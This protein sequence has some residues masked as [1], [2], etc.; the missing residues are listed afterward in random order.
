MKKILFVIPDLVVGGAEIYLFKITK[1][2]SEKN[3]ISVLV[4]GCSSSNLKKCFIKQKNIKFFE[5][6]SLGF[7]SKL[8]NLYSFLK[9]KNYDKVISFLNIANLACLIS[10]MLLYNRIK[11]SISI[12]N[13]LSGYY[14][15]SFKD[16]I[17]VIL[18]RLLLF[19]C[20]EVI[21]NSKFSKDE[22]ENTFLFPKSKTR[23]IYNPNYDDTFKKE[24]KKNKKNTY[25]NYICAIGSLT[26][27]KNF[28]FL[29]KVF[30]KLKKKTSQN[31]IIVGDG[32]Q[33][34]Y[35]KNY[36]QE[37]KLGKRVIL[38][39]KVFPPYHFIKK[40]DLII[41]CSLWEGLPNILVE[42]ALLKKFIIASDCPGGIREIMKFYSNFKVFKID[43]K[44]ELAELILNYKKYKKN[45]NNIDKLKQKFHQKNCEYYLK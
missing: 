39:G 26:K 42:S 9:K 12:R 23:L 31:L 38:L 1:F 36:I 11:L 18:I 44:D 25:K 3:D 6:R 2:L 15:Q 30:N 41:S 40:A 19:F 10:N 21:F 35:L 43:D 29:L 27:Q 28:I 24:I 34:S 14:K 17:I 20:K 33:K 4:L 7:F 37:Q 22:A 13:V 45:L 16:K 32:E 5:F 8:F